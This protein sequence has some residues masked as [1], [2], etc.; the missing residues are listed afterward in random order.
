MKHEG[1]DG[2]EP[3]HAVHGG[4]DQATL[5]ATGSHE[6]KGEGA[7]ARDDQDDESAQPAGGTSQ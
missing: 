2:G 5:V 1:D 6:R 3:G 4:Q 7:P